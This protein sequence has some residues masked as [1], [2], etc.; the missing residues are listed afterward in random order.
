M[1]DMKKAGSKPHKTNLPQRE[2]RIA[3]HVPFILESDIEDLEIEHLR[4]FLN[5]HNSEVSTR[6]QLLQDA[7]KTNYPIFGQVPK[8]DW[9]PD[10]RIA[11]NFAKYMV[12]TNTGFFAGIP[13][14]VT[15]KEEDEE[16]SSYLDYLNSY[17]GLDDITAELAKMCDIYGYAY[18]LYFVDEDARIGITFVSPMDGFM[19]YDDSL[20]RRKRYFV[21]TYKDRN[22]ILHGSVSDDK[23]V[24]YFEMNPELK[25]TADPPVLHGF[26]GVPAEEY[27]ENEECIGIFEPVYSLINNYNKA[28]SEKANDVDYFSDAYLK[29][30]GAKLNEEEIQDI[31]SHRVINFKGQDADKMIVEFL[32]KPSGDETQEHLLDRLERLIFQIGMVADISDDNFGTASGI[33]IRYRLW[34]MQGLA[35]TKARKFTAS[36]NERYRLIFSNPLVKERGVYADSWVNL[37]YK[38]TQNYPANLLE[39]AEIASKLSGITSK[40]TQLKVLSVVSDV[41][42]EIDKIQEDLDQTGYQTSFPTNRTAEEGEEE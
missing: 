37:D 40:E 8:P 3:P 17:N 6:L 35:D 38:F 42:T 10:H 4:E 22:G 20:V 12:D 36:M 19:I 34:A 32:A 13:P 39:E 5:R 1:T 31:R 18:E 2:K 25:W 11:V 41:A 33:A 16:L 30:L 9:K 28:I 24:R 23:S 7:Y 26:D 14:K 29:I 21:R 27:I 15:A